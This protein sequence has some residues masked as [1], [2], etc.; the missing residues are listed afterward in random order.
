MSSPRFEAFLARLYSDA[1]FLNRFLDSPAEAMTDA[2]L[3]EREQLAAINIDRVGLR[4]AARSYGAKR[5]SRKTA[6]RPLWQRALR[7][8]TFR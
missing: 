5:A 4:M 6:R 8:L 2:A 7:A 3:D 1:A